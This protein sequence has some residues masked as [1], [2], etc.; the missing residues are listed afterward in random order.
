MV[1]ASGQGQL[2]VMERFYKTGL[3]YSK[4]VWQAAI[5]NR[6]LQVVQHL[7]GREKTVPVITASSHAAA[8]RHLEVFEY[9]LEML[10]VFWQF[11][12]RDGRILVK[13]GEIRA[14]V[15]DAIRHCHLDVIEYLLNGWNPNRGIFTLGAAAKGCYLHVIEWLAERGSS[16]PRN[17]AVVEFFLKNPIGSTFHA[18]TSAAQNGHLEIIKLFHRHAMIDTES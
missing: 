18:V 1:A 10:D 6:H 3:K 15:R 14:A 5:E 4:E 2:D 11:L 17:L 9:L 8:Y 16:H 13:T 12:E 7:C